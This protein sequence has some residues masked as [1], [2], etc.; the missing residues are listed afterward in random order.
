MEAAEWLDP[1]EAALVDVSLE[2][3]AEW[4]APSEAALVDLP[5]GVAAL[6]DSPVEVAAALAAAEQA[7]EMELESEGARPHQES[8]KP[9]PSGSS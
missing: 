8:S 1:S 2:V 6:V 5:A 7:V 4:L 3:A 9:A